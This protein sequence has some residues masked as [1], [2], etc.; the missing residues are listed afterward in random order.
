MNTQNKNQMQLDQPGIDSAFLTLLQHHRSGQILSDLSAAM[1]E[2]TEAAQLQGKPAAITLKITVKPASNACGAVVVVDD[3]KTK[4]PTPEKKGS[5][6]FSDDAGNLFRDDPRQKELPL[7][8]TVD[9]GKS[10][11]VVELK[12]VAAN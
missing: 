2:V 6:F 12:K 7:L 1:R 10:F 5:F 9:G 4:L 11:D 3:I 8:K